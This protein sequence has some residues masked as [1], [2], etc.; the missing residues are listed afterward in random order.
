MCLFVLSTRKLVHLVMTRIIPRRREDFLNLIG[1]MVYTASCQCICWLGGHN[2]LQ[3]N[4][5]TGS[6]EIHSLTVWTPEAHNQGAGM[7]DSYWRLW[8]RMC[9]SMFG[10]PQQ[11]PW[12]MA[13]H[14]DFRRLPMAFSTVSCSFFSLFS[15]GHLP[16]AA[17]PTLIH[18]D[19]ISMTL[20][21]SVKTFSKRG[22]MSK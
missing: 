22:P 15:Q 8:G 3:Q 20:I 9:S 16:L 13:D 19:L 11:V 4:W 21:T 17:A 2:T 5:V 6:T 18:N 7:V 12:L 14:S 10:D 1:L